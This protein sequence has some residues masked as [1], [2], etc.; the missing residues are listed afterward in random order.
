MW[1]QQLPPPRDSG[2]S[3]SRLTP[4]G[5]LKREESVPAHTRNWLSPREEAEAAS[6]E[7]QLW[8]DTVG[9][10]DESKHIRVRYTSPHALG[11]LRVSKQYS[12]AVACLARVPKFSAQ[13]R[14][15][16]EHTG[17]TL[18]TSSPQA[19]AAPYVLSPQ[20]QVNQSQM[21]R[22]VYRRP[23]FA[24]TKLKACFL[25]EAG[26]RSTSGFATAIRVATQK[27]NCTSIRFDTVSAKSTF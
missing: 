25:A 10:G 2:R 21:L 26:G 27:H 3:E 18:K 13:V 7:P 8:A 4:K 11:S 1:F 17:A 12:G 24:V 5:I 19:Q 16:L 23:C 14:S 20:A 6:E 9:G 22:C 15:I